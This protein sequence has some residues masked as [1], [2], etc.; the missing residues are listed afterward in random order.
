MIASLD[1]FTSRPLISVVIPNYNIELDWLR[2]AIQSVRDQIYPHWELCISDDASTVSGT[3]EFLNNKAAEDKR[4]RLAFRETNGHISANSNSALALATGEYVALMDADDLISPDALYWVA[5]AIASHPDV[6]LLFSDEDKIDK[7]GERFDP[8][9]KSA[10]N[11]ALML[12]QNAFSHLGVFR[13]SLIEKVGSFRE[14]FEGAQD[15]DLVLRCAEK[16]SPARI[17]HIPRVLYHWRTLPGSTS[18]SGYSKPYA[19]DAGRRAIEE[20]LKRK[21]IAASVEPALSG[22][23][24]ISYNVPAAP[25]LVSIVVISDLRTDLSIH[26]LTSILDNTTYRNFDLVIS[27]SQEDLYAAR[28]A[29]AAALL[30]DRRVRTMARDSVRSRYATLIKAAAETRG[31]LLCLLDDDIASTSSTW[32]DQLVSRAMLDDVGIA[33]PMICSPSGN[34]LQAGIILGVDGLA[35]HPFHG[36]DCRSEGYFGR[37]ALEQDYTSL[38]SACMV[39]SRDALQGSG[40]FDAELTAPFDAIDF[41]LRIRRSGLRTVWVPAAKMQQY[42]SRDERPRGRPAKLQVSSDALRER[43]KHVIDDDPCYNPNLSLDPQRVFQLD[44]QPRHNLLRG[45]TAEALL[46]LTSSRIAT[47]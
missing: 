43:W 36:I 34:I 35:G 28:L 18:V 47:I 8:Y 11:P 32:L 46:N 25:P 31:S 2:D 44:V 33:A 9:F 5:H 39:I 38:S 12:S 3:R 7:D 1:G 4:I 45:K 41:C 10:W 23:Y 21:V 14:G 20:H 26:C 22:Y 19:W 16:T 40:E 37:A 27:I 15:H 24:Q 42:P 30:N 13:R 6:D 17:R 29:K